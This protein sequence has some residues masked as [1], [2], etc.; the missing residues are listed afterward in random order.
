MGEPLIGTIAFFVLLG[1][2]LVA[3]LRYRSRR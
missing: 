3:W 2:A 1:F